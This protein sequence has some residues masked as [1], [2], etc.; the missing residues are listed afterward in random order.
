LIICTSFASAKQKESL[1]LFHKQKKKKE[2]EKAENILIAMA[3]T[4]GLVSLLLPQLLQGLHDYAQ[5]PTLRTQIVPILEEFVDEWLQ[6][7]PH[8]HDPTQLADLGGTPPSLLLLF[9]FIYK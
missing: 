7:V 6:E 8:P 1:T 2:K 3:T 4:Q 5:V 9:F